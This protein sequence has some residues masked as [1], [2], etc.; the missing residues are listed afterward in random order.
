MIIYRPDQSPVFVVCF[1]VNSSLLS[2]FH[3][4]RECW[5]NSHTSLLCY[6]LHS[7]HTGYSSEHLLFTWGSLSF[8]LIIA[9][10]RFHVIIPVNELNFN[11]TGWSATF[12]FIGVIGARNWTFPWFKLRVANT[13]SKDIA[14][15][16]SCLRE[17][18]LNSPTSRHQDHQQK[19]IVGIS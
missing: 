13:S 5:R 9:D 15:V 3:N 16:N 2:S 4:K 1:L 6:I 12:N 19:N 11:S 8:G 17:Q 18:S 14:E 7:Q 10:V